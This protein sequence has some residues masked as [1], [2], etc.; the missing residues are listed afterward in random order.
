L[1]RSRD[2]GVVVLI[3]VAVVAGIVVLVAREIDP[4]QQDRDLLRMRRH[5]GFERPLGEPPPRHLRA[6]DEDHP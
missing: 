5:D 6:D 2:V 4:V 3:L 1:R